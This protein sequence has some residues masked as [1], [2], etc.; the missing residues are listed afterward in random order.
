MIGTD[1]EAIS[2]IEKLCASDGVMRKVFTGAEIDYAFAHAKPYERLC[3]FY[4]AKEAFAKAVR[5]GFD[6]FAPIDIEVVHE[7]SGAPKLRLCRAARIAADNKKVEV[8]ISH[9]GGFAVA[10]VCILES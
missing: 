1:I 6:G 2:R 10:V 8:S 5:I 4:C 3:G 9:S 7:E